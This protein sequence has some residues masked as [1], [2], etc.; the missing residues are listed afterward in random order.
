MKKI[1]LLLPL[2]AMMACNKQVENPPHEQGNGVS[3]LKESDRFVE[4]LRTYA[5][6]QPDGRTAAA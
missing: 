3:H 1:W 4:R 5:H 2:L 6:D